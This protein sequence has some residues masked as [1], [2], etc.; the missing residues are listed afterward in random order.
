MAIITKGSN[1]QK[2]SEVEFTLNITDLLAHASVSGDAYFSNQSNWDKVFI[3]YKSSTGNQKEILIFKDVDS[4][5]TSVANFG[6]FSGARDAF[7]V[8]SI[9]IMDKQ[10]GYLHVKRSDLVVAD[11]DVDLDLNQLILDTTYHTLFSTPSFSDWHQVNSS[12]QKIGVTYKSGVDYTLDSVTLSLAKFI[13]NPT[14]DMVI[15]VYELDQDNFSVTNLLGESNVVNSSVITTSLLD[16]VPGSI[17]ETVFDF[18]N[19]INLSGS[20]YY[21]IQLETGVDAEIYV[22]H[23]TSSLINGEYPTF[24]RYLNFSYELGGLYIKIE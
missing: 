12:N 18:D 8:Q 19:P 23:T 24:G 5:A 10:G 16:V 15:K 4:G 11:F 7:E 20:K 13:G 6:V 2:G 21:A 17:P 1:L 9:I 14:A 22:L 3:N